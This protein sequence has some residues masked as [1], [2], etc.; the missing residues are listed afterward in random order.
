MKTKA[1]MLR[2]NSEI[3]WARLERALHEKFGVNAVTYDKHGDRRTCGDIDT[4]NDICHLIKQHL[5]GASQICASVLTAMTREARI[6]KR[7]VTDECAA[8]MYR[9]VVP[10]L[11]DDRIDG[12]VSACGRPFMSPE[13]IYT[14]YIHKTTDKSEKDILKL[15]SKLDPITPRTVKMIIGYITNYAGAQHAAG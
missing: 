12:F 14:H 8:G 7:Y 9:I 2:E 6:R 13:R 1:L 3:D 15:L 10:V 4:A 5:K 11:R